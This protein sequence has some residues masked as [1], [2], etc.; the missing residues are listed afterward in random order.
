MASSAHGAVRHVR[1]MQMA[2]SLAKRGLGDVAPNPAVGCIIVKNGLIVGRGRTQRGGRPHAERVALLE[3]GEAA[4]GADVYVTLEPCAHT[5]QTSPCAIALVE[6]KVKRVFIAILDKDERVAGKGVQILEDAGIDVQ[7]GLCA[8]A[9]MRVNQGF[10]LRFD[11]ERPL[12]TSKI[13][14]TIDSKIAL[15]NGESK[16]ITGEKARSFGH[17]L[18]ARH[19]AILVGVNTVL[20]DDPSLTCR[21][22]GLEDWSPVRIIMDRTLR[23]PILSKLVQTAHHI[24]TYIITEH[25][26]GTAAYQTLLEYGVQLITLSDIGDIKAVSKALVDKGITR[27]LIEGGGQIHASF[28]KAGVVDHIEQFIAGSV[29]GYDGTASVGEMNFHSLADIPKYQSATIRKIGP[30]ILASWDKAE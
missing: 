30:D 2:L 6:A 10:F 5:G 22:P 14:G 23:T 21:L 26:A 11:Q 12:F 29:I 3:A 7:F 18:R 4:E 24:P 1:Y 20:K 25:A 27:V 16:W 19:D 9:A 13:A 8:Q 28:L 17:M 15:V